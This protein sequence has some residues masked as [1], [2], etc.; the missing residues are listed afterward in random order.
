MIKADVLDNG[1]V[2]VYQDT[3]SDSIKFEKIRFK[4]PVSWEGYTKTAVFRN[5]NTVVSVVLN[6]GGEMCTGEDECLVP[7]EVIKTPAFT[8]SVF[9]VNEESIATSVRATVKVNQSGYEQGDHPSEPTPDEYAQIL[10]IAVRAETIANSVRTDAEN[11]KFDGETGPRGE[12]GDKGDPGPQGEKGEKGDTGDTGPQ[13]EKGEKGDTGDTG[14]QGEKGEKGDKG[15]PGPQGEKGEKGDKGDPGP[16]GEKG[17]PGELQQVTPEDTTFFD[18]VYSPNLLNLN[19]VSKGY[20]L[21]E[22]GELA[23][24]PTYTTSDYIPCA[25]GDTVRHQFNYN[26]IRYDNVDKPSYASF[27]RVCAYDAD[28]QFV[29]GS[30]VQYVSLYNVP[31]NTAYIR[32]SYTVWNSGSFSDSAIIISD[33]SEIVPFIEYGAVLSEQISPQY[34]PTDSV[35]AFLPDEICCAVGR[36]VEIYNSQVC[37]TAEK[38]HF[39]WKCSIGKAMKRKFSFTGMEENI[40]EYELSL[41]IYN[42]SFGALWSGSTKLKIVPAHTGTLSICCIGDSF[43]NCKPWL[44]ELMS[45]NSG[46]SGVGTMSGI[47]NDSQGISHQIKFEGRSGWTAA[48]YLT[49]GD[50]EENPS[51]F[52]YINPFYNTANSRFD[53][54][55][56]VE[57]KLS[58]VSP[59]A[60]Q[61]FLGTNGIKTDPTEN[62]ENIKKIIDYIRQ[63]NADIPVFVVNTIYCSDQNGIGVQTASDGYTAI[64]S[65]KY[66]YEED[67][68]VFNLMKA[69][70]ETLKEYGNLYFVP[71]AI[72]HDSEY[73]FGNTEVN[74]NPRSSRTEFVP[75][76]SVHPQKE[77]YYQMA[78]IMFSTISAHI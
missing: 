78:D 76:E 39:K 73:N 9:G 71:A 56:Y 17:E 18:I 42:D 68:K 32:V 63:D 69:L 37:P 47:S 33:S 16:Q 55:Y 58:G 54:N 5:G 48:K 8:V 66:K 62:V 20:Y 77:G 31:E 4:F 45:L 3:V 46:I 7:H 74:V 65:G 49:A 25:P 14:P 34:I 67:I 51:E 70:N 10:D 12:K 28:K 13:G 36:T 41:Y 40:G 30:Y 75:K 11:G 22:N 64:Y 26:N 50:A 6:N 52:K 61:I 23:S 72:C 15:D 53:W 38:Y 59:D 19:A 43:T 35:K 2:A 1:M 21:K 29:T 24:N 57:N 44:A 60:V 27:A